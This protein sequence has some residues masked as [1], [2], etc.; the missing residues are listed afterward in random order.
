M[1]Q[2]NKLLNKTYLVPPQVDRGVA[3][4]P[5]VVEAEAAEEAGVGAATEIRTL[6][7]KLQRAKILIALQ[8]AV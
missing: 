3:V 2:L 1:V 7:G 6:H 4:R 5:V 8:N